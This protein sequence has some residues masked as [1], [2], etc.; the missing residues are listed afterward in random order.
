VRNGQRCAVVFDIDNTLADSRQRTL[1][2]ARRYGEAH[3][4]DA[5]AK[6]ELDGVGYDGIDTLKRLRF[7]A[8]TIATIGP[9]FQKE[10]EAFFWD[11]NNFGL[12][13]RIDRIAKLADLVR[14]N[15]G[16]VFYLTGRIERLRDRTRTQLQD[17]ELPNA[18]DAH[19]IMKPRLGIRTD[20]FKAK[21][22][23]NKLDQRPGVKILAFVSEGRKDVGHIQ[24]NT[25]VRALL[26]D[27]PIDRE[28][29]PLRKKTPI[30]PA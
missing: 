17:L 22:L 14:E 1:A 23:R 20:R 25:N 16:E 28:A 26:Y 5:L 27:F 18:D 30:I 4:I 6:L 24:R 2:F 21:R 13:T 11:P 29:A 12:D 19:L 3:G 7:D 10:W 8:E 9:T 15:G